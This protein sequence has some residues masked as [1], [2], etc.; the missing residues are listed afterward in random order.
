MGDFELEEVVGNGTAS[1]SN[2]PQTSG[3]RSREESE[4][5]ET[6]NKRAREDDDDEDDDEEN[7]E[8]EEVA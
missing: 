7:I 2:T 3:K 6:N 8:F 1:Q 4:A 5:G